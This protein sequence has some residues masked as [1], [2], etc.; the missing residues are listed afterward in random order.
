MGLIEDTYSVTNFC[1]GLLISFCYTM[2][3]SQI[4]GSLPLLHFYEKNAKRQNKKYILAEESEIAV[5]I[6]D[7]Y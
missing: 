2:S 7:T 5:A 6:N 1:V 3:E 4:K